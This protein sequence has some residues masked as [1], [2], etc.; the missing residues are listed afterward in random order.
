MD[1][2]ENSGTPV[3]RPARPLVSVVIPTRNSEQT[4]RL[5]LNSTL[6]QT[7]SNVEIVVVDQASE[8]G[9][10]KI[11]EESGIEVISIPFGGIYLPPTVS[12]NVGTKVSRGRYL[13]HIDSDMELT[14]RVI[15]S[16]IE[17]ALQGEQA[18][19]IPEV[20]FS[21]NFWGRC[22]ALER[23]CYLGD[24][25][26]ET[27]RFFSWDILHRIRGYDESLRGGEDWDISTRLRNARVPIARTKEC[28]Y[29]HIEDFDFFKNLRKKYNGGRSF[30]AYRN[31]HPQASTQTLTVLRSAFWRNRSR[32]ARD[33]LHATGFGI[34]KLLEAY[35]TWRGMLKPLNPDD[36]SWPLQPH[37]PRGAR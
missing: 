7:Y 4:L 29:H 18:I 26:F 20:D 24:P 33:P 17:L 37:V 30:Q 25:I 22:K 36:R 15:E 12:R 28:L 32:L 3:G 19:I 27:P 13:L 8:D 1:S 16:C 23:S 11:A 6:R 2:I 34:Q 14:P 31:K 5:C 9:T 21:S 35:C 10:R